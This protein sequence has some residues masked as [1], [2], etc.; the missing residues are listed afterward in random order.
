M[1]IVAKFCHQQGIWVIVTTHSP[2]IVRRIPKEHIRLLVRGKGSVA[3]VA[4]ATGLNVGLL[5]G[6]GV[7]YS[8]VILVEDDSA[9]AF[10]LAVL[11]QLE[12]EMLR[13]FEIVIAESASNITSVLQSMPL[14]RSWLTLIGTY[15]GDMRKTVDGTDFRW[16]FGFLPGDVDPERLL[17]ALA[18]TTPDIAT[19]LAAEL[20]RSLTDITVALNCVAGLDYHDY[21]RDFAGALNIDIAIVR[22]AFVRVW[23]QNA[24]N[25]DASQR[26]IEDIRKAAKGG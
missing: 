2:T 8:A 24:D 20:G 17:K 15:D 16:P 14:T 21:F 13:Q 3:F 10:L 25:L 26:L 23:L 11:E 22:R 1:N 7:A 6:G 18:D 4:P 9:K 5:L 12:P 19:V